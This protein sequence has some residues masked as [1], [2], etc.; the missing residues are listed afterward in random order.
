MAESSSK[1]HRSKPSIKP[2][3]K[4]KRPLK[5]KRVDDEN[6]DDDVKALKTRCKEVE[7]RCVYL[8]QLYETCS[9]ELATFRGREQ[10][11]LTWEEVR[12]MSVEERA[13]QVLKK[14]E[15]A[16]TCPLYVFTAIRT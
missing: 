6:D 1:P 16:F 9:K 11:L 15:N 10:D 3:E 8:E 13:Q 2:P 12:S 14:I 5:R 7:A 4:E